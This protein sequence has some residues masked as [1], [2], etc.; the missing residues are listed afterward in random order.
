[1]LVD[2]HCHLHL[3]DYNLLGMSMDAVLQKALDNGVERLL[4]VCTTL[5]DVPTILAISV[6]YP[7]ISASIGLHPN[8]LTEQEPTVEQL[9]TY[10]A[11]PT[12]VAIGETGLDYYRGSQD[13]VKQ[14]ER[15]VAHIQAAKTLD[16]P[17]IIHTRLAKKDTLEI[18]SHE[19]AS[20]V[21]GVFHCFTE[22]WETAKRALDLNFYISF[23]GIVTFKNA[24]ELQEIAQKIP[25]DRMLIETDAPYLAPVPYRGKINQPAY[26][27]EI[28]EYIAHLRGVSFQDVA[29]K[30]TDNFYRLFK[31]ALRQ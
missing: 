31:H 10:A 1:M 15:F 18:L 14:K 3:I 2:S 7:H 16:K 22:D 28:A 29:I 30:T 5:Q 25:I 24:L 21:G 26:V 11:H 13:S 12:V 8:E 17:L 27:K 23:S 9:T 20:D 19:Q 6:R 4:C